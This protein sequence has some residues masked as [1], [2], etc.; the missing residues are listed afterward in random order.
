M[1]ST[2]FKGVFDKVVRLY[3]RDPRKQVNSGISSAIVDHI[4]DRVRTICQGW[5]WPEWVVTEERAFRPVWSSGEQYARVSSDGTPEEVF[6]LG[7]AYVVNGDFGAGYGY[8][9]VK[10]TAPADPPVGTVP[11]NATYWE[12]MTTVDSFIAYNQRDRRSIGTVLDVYS[13]NPRVPTGSMGGRRRYSPSEKG[14]DVPGGGV[15]VFITQKMPV[16]SY[17]LTPYVFGKTYVRAD[18]VFD[19]ATGECYQ[20]INTTTAA[21]TDAAHWNWVPFL[22]VWEDYVTK[23]AFADALMEYDQSG[24]GD[25]QAKIAL[26]QYWNQAAD[27]ALQSEVDQLV[28]QGQKLQYNFGRCRTY[29]REVESCAFVT[30]TDT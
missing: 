18:V 24:N 4:N 29:A 16:P 13:R 3:G 8:Y 12:P 26:V 7:A 5:L 11:T 15:T 6:Y 14:I 10:A 1:R 2:K 22:Q 25:L 23:G 20:A 19:I 27:D 9:R 21:V 17:T 28:I 30:I